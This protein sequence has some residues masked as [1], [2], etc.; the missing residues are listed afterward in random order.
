[1]Y[2]KFIEDHAVGKHVTALVDLSDAVVDEFW[3]HPAI[4]AC[5][6]CFGCCNLKC[7]GR[8]EITNFDDI[9]FLR[10]K[11]IGGL[12]VAVCQPVLVDVVYPSSYLQS[13]IEAQL[14]GRFPLFS[15]Q[16]LVQGHVG[17]LHADVDGEHILRVCNSQEW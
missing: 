4:G 15:I 7:F 1:M 9:F 10:K 8:P 17:P 14:R 13:P 16:V 12:E 2:K 3:S 11:D 5:L 6:T